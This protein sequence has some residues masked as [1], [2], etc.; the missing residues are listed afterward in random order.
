MQGSTQHGTG[1]STSTRTTDIG[2]AGY[3]VYPYATYERRKQLKMNWKI[4]SSHQSSD[5]YTVHSTQNRTESGPK[6]KDRLGLTLIIRTDA[7]S[8]SIS[9]CS[10][11]VDEYRVLQLNSTA[12]QLQQQAAMADISYCAIFSRVLVHIICIRTAVVRAETTLPA[13]LCFDMVWMGTSVV[14]LSCCISI[15]PRLHTTDK[16][17]PHPANNP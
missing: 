6:C 13:G 8:P 15:S 9:L 17:E 3:E 11:M 4:P 5:K 14:P 7:I 2:C 12:E 10:R 16:P 1:S